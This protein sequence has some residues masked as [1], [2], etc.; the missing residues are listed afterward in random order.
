M[1][2]T[3]QGRGF[4]GQA[5]NR[6]DARS[7]CSAIP[8]SLAYWVPHRTQSI[9]GFSSPLRIYLYCSTVCRKGSMT[10][11]SFFTRI[12]KGLAGGGVLLKRW[13]VT[14]CSLS[15]SSSP[16][17]HLNRRASIPTARSTY[18]LSAPNT[19]SLCA[20]VVGFVQMSLDVVPLIAPVPARSLH[21]RVE[22][23][24][25]VTEA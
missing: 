17:S 15:D 11:V 24:C 5:M 23:M 12:F 18:G 9:P 6:Q 19:L 10:S 8:P 22:V 3:P 7:R 2:S 20:A 16:C 14:F 21:T 4:G 13:T 1:Y 25:T